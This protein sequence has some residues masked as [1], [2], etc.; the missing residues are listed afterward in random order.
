M[1][2]R[3]PYFADTPVYKLHHWFSYTLLLKKGLIKEEEEEAKHSEGH[4]SFKD[5]VKESR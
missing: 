2:D 3:T 5:R 1:S 4:F